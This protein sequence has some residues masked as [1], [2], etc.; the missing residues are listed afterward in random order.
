[1]SRKNAVDVII[2]AFAMILSI[3]LPGCFSAMNNSPVLGHP[4]SVGST[5][6]AGVLDVV[7]LPLQVVAFGFCAMCELPIGGDSFT[8][9]VRDVDGNPV[10]DAEIRGKKV[11]MISS[12]VK[13]LTDKNGEATFRHYH[14]GEHL[15]R[16]VVTHE[17]YYRFGRYYGDTVSFGVRRKRNDVEQGPIVHNVILKEIRQPVSM[18]YIHAPS[19]VVPTTNMWLGVDLESFQWTSPYGNGKHNDMLLRFNYEMHDKYAEQWATMDVSF[20]NNPCA[21]FYL[22][23]KDLDSQFKSTYHAETNLVFS[24]MDT[25][26]MV[27]PGKYQYA[28]GKEDYMVFRTRTIVDDKGNLI[29]AHYGKI[30]GP[31]KFGVGINVSDI[32][33]NP[34]PNDTNLESK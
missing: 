2:V 9:C 5:V 11:G 20:T 1:M 4:G 31:W 34:T 7:T 24:Q 29:S 6:C 13:C 16:V 21:G 25:Y 10:P 19:I 17:G 8:V 33:F 15:S 23:K 14:E 27:F 26:R 12:N 18:S 22:R 28:L 30:Y 32:Y 3:G